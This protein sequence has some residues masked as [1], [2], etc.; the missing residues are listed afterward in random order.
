MVDSNG[1]IRGTLYGKPDGSV[2]IQETDSGADRE[3]ALAPDG[4]FSAPSVETESVTTEVASIGELVGSLRTDASG[5]PQ[6]IPHDTTTKVEYRA[7]NR[8]DSDVVDVD[9]DNDEITIQEAGVYQIYARVYWD[10]DSNWSQGDRTDTSVFVNGSSESTSR[11]L[12]G[13]DDLQTHDV[14]EIISLSE[15]D[16]IDI[17]VSQESGDEIDLRQDAGGGVTRFRFEV[18]R[19][20]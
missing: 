13:G 12:V 17:R 10:S 4:T 14:T 1:V 9:V 3:V 16:T 20:G 18:V 6:T 19:L 5:D 11:A 8:E 2:A 7:V 15:N